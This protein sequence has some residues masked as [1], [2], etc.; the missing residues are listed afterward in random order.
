MENQRCSINHQ[1]LKNLQSQPTH[2]YEYFYYT[3]TS[4][5]PKL[6]HIKATTV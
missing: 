1:G 2:A 3:A 4:S 5:G 6:G